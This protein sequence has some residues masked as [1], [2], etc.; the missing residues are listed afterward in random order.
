[1]VKPSASNAKPVSSVRKEHQSATKLGVLKTPN[2]NPNNL[3]TNS[4]MISR[5]ESVAAKTLQNNASASH[6]SSTNNDAAAA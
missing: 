6:I 5:S 4:S 2:T 1:M 3:Q